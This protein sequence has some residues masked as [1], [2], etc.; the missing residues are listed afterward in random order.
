LDQGSQHFLVTV[1]ANSGGTIQVGISPSIATAVSGQKQQ[2]S[3]TVSGTPYTGVKWS[4]SSGS[5]STSGLYSAPTVT[6]ETTAIITA[7]SVFDQSKS[8]SA[9]V[10]INPISTQTL[11]ITTNSIPGAEQGTGYSAAFNAIGGT[12]TYTWTISGGSIPSGLTLSANGNF[13]GIPTATGT[14]NFAVTVT[15]EVDKTASANFSLNVAGGSNFDGPAELPRVTVPSAMSDTP[16]PGSTITVNAGGDLQAA[17]NNARCGDV[18]SLQE[19]AT[20]TGM[21]TVPAKNCDTNHWI[22]VRTSAADSA[23]PSEGQRTTPCY[24]GVASLPGR[25]AYACQHPQ[26]VLAKVQTQTQGNGPFQIA[27]NANF[28]RLIGLEITRA[29]GTPASA[30]LISAKGTADH[31]IV[32]RS[33]LHGLSQDETQLGVDL[34]GVSNAAVVDSYFSDFHC[35]SIAGTCT[36]AHAIAG[37]IGSSQD[38]PY[39]IQNNFIE[40]A[41][42]GVL[43]GGGAATLTPADIQILNNHFWKPWQWMPGH[44]GFVGGMGGHPFIVKNHLELKNAA[45][46]LVEGNLM[47]NTW[48]GFSQS[49]YSILLTPKNQH[50]QGG[51]DICP[52]CQVTDVTIRYGRL[53]HAGG[54]IQMATAISG[55]GTNGAAALAGARWSIHDLVIDDLSTSYVGSGNL[56]LIMNVWPTHPLNSITINHVTGFPDP[57]SHVLSLGNIHGATAPMY[58][59]VFTNNMVATGRYPVW[60]TGGTTSCAFND[61]PL[62]SISRCFTSYTFANNAL[63]A[64]PSNFPPSVWPNGNM[65]PQTT[66]SAGFVSYNNANGGNYE[67]LPSSIYKNKGTDEKD[68]GADIIAINAALANVE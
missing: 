40:A 23:L 45:R 33:W 1:A 13:G 42:E 48:G 37:G 32:D 15:D 29:A 4:A 35:V 26:N 3:A 56:F 19:G 38:G 2:F 11:R 7:T 62:T 64:T 58:G 47:E 6:S 66:T 24:A 43:F 57:N 54:G 46:V 20:F 8:A 5:I 41:A 53:S 27:P 50:T 17:L 9:T 14:F 12:G 59:F 25:P 16:A 67:L 65:F 34:S 28:Y 55:N 22:I 61:V 51:S 49:G 52:L 36:D 68:L 18:I 63:V 10:T 39:K 30:K 21:F 31:L 44:A 60:N